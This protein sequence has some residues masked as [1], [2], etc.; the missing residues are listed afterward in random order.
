LQKSKK[1]LPTKEDYGTQRSARRSNVFTSKLANSSRGLTSHHLIICEHE[2]GNLK[3]QTPE[4]YFQKSLEK[5]EINGKA[6]TAYFE[7]N[8][9]DPALNLLAQ[10]IEGTQGIS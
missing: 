6:I 1:N 3:V 10:S 4:F 2:P 9:K 8:Q 5:A 7:D